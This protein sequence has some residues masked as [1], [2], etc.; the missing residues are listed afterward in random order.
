MQS[1]A[2]KMDSQV[3]AFLTAMLPGMAS[4]YFPHLVAVAA[5]AAFS[6]VGSDHFFLLSLC[7]EQGDQMSW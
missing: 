1:L 7:P 4:L 5:A 6:R 3:S 2:K